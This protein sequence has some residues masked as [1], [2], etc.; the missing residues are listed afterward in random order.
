MKIVAI[1]DIHGKENPDFY[2][3]LDENDID[4]VLICGDITNF[5]PLDFVKKFIDNVKST[6]VDIIGIHGNC[7]PEGVSEEVVNS[8]AIFIHN[9]VVSYDDVILFGFGGS[10]PTPFNTPSEFDDSVIYESL[11]DLFADYDFVNNGDGKLHLL[12][13]HAPPFD[14]LVDELPDGGHAGSMGVRKIIEEF[15]PDINL[16]G[17]IHESRSK[18]KINNTLIFNPGPLEE[19]YVVLIEVIDKS[20]FTA[21]LIN[22]TD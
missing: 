12:V 5:G 11:K 8:G 22:I 1:T 16:C 4:L 21:N 13:T 3:Y 2:K 10:N 18:D 20:N 19:N 7:D 9:N 6:G 17:H 15:Q 14:T